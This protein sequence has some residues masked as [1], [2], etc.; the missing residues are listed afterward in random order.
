MDA[1]TRLL[2]KMTLIREFENIL[3]EEK[4]LRNIY[5][6][7]HCCNGQEAVAVGVCS[8]LQKD[9]YIVTN[10]RPHGHAIAKGANIN[11]LMAEIYGKKSGT[12]CGKGGSMHV[13]DKECGIIAATGIVGSG[14]PVA[15]GAA[16]SSKY[17][18]DGKVTCV[19][20]GDGAANEGTFYES[21]NLAAIWKLPIIFV[22]EDNGVAVTTMTD[23]TSA[24]RDYT[25]VAKAFDIKTRNLNGQ[26]VEEMYVNTSMIVE[27]VRENSE[28]YLIQAKTIRFREH[29]EGSYYLNMRKSGYRDL[30]KLTYDEENLCPIRLYYDKLLTQEKITKSEYEEMRREIEENVK[31]A[32]EFANNS[33]L[34]SVESVFDYVFKEKYDAN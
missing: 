17:K 23:C 34:P 21:L 12:N 28:P 29:A 31:R 27:A 22:V 2:Y 18:G 7:V 3:S 14:I 16:F 13:I 8:A 11:A 32:L 20:L 6:M 1:A 25:K 4:L 15:C 9:D 5:G 26:D 10:H 33:E 19:F 30:D 24:C